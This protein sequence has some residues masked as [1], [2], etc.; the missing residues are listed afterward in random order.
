VTGFLIDNSSNQFGRPAGV[1]VMKDGA[2]LFSDD[3]NGVIYRVSYQK[4]TANK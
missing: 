4:N 3:I 2:L 1:T